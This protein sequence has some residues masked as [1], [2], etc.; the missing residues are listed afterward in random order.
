MVH[1]IHRR[2]FLLCGS[3]VM[4]EK[5]SQ[6]SCV[7]SAKSACLFFS[8]HWWKVWNENNLS[9]KKS[10]ALQQKFVCVKDVCVCQSQLS[11]STFFFYICLSHGCGKNL[12]FGAAT[13]KQL[14]ASQLL[15]FNQARCFLCVQAAGSRDC[16]KMSQK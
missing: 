12:S 16:L 3:G 15:K 5:K 2:L 9:N 8:C 13:F 1:F 4:L 10:C 11:S 7:F 14:L 6:L